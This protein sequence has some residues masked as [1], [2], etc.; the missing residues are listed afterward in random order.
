MERASLCFGCVNL[1]VWFLRI[2]LVIEHRVEHD[3]E[4]NALVEVVK[5]H[6]IA[7]EC[8]INGKKIEDAARLRQGNVIQL[9]RTN[10]F[11]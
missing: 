4:A 3:A 1:Q 2:A 5:L 8:S 11:R 9:G 6:P 10:I 7:E